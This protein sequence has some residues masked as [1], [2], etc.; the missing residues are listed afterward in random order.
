MERCC[1]SRSAL[2]VNDLSAA[3][4]HP[5]ALVGEL[6][7]TPELGRRR[8]GRWRVGDF[9]QVVKWRG[10]YP[11]SKLYAD[12]GHFLGVSPWRHS[13]SQAGRP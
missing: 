4:G 10:T 11:G 5:H 1:P 2:R 13:F 3:L 9:A 8:D 7:R 6:T 12:F